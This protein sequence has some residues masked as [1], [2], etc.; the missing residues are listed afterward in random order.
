MS[1]RQ[2]TIPPFV[3]ANFYADSLVIINSNIAGDIAMNTKNN[4]LPKQKNA[5]VKNNTFLEIPT[6]NTQITTIKFLGNNAKQICIVVN[7][8]NEVFIS[9][10]ALTLL[11]KMLGA[12]NLTIN[13]VAIVNMATAFVTI[14]NIQQQLNATKLL[15]F[16]VTAQQLQI[17]FAIPNYKLQNYNGYTIVQ[18]IALEKMLGNSD[19]EK[20]EKKQLWDCLQ[21]LFN[22]K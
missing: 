6:A 8:Q 15:L 9:D 21:Q 19:A 17:P 1:L 14:E 10:E 13:D 11:S 16:S 4:E 18:A 22:L 20:K 7:I 2:I 3:L 5:P 12:C